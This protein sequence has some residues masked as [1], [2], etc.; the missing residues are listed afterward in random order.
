M[1]SNIDYV[2]YICRIQIHIVIDE[3]LIMKLFI[4]TFLILFTSTLFS[5][6][7][8]VINYHFN[9]Q[10]DTS[11]SADPKTI[12]LYKASNK[13]TGDYVLITSKQESTFNK[14]DKINNN[15][16]NDP[17]IKDIP[18]PSVNIYN[19]FANNY[20]LDNL[21]FRGKKLLIKDSLNSFKWIIKRDLD[22][23]LGY[24]VKKA[25]AKKANITYEAWFAP[26][27]PFKS[28]PLSYFGLPGAILKLA[29]ILD[30]NDG[31][32]KRS[33]TATEVKLDNNAVILKPTKGK[34]L[35]K[36]EFE[37]YFN[38]IFRIE[39]EIENNKV[40]TNIN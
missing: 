11:T 2:I 30:Q 12:E 37:D 26:S 35:T 16:D 10:F 24:K 3:T 4:L 40:D 18:V 31:V 20:S 17:S 32:H 7:K 13:N 25:I 6:N 15:Q 28:G 34:I 33:Y 5:Q 1:I 27:L 9:Y 19:D 14:I 38:E 22:D 21:D 23:I 39:A 8:L 36:K 29:I